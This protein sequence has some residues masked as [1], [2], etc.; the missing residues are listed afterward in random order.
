MLRA[1]GSTRPWG[2]RGGMPKCQAKSVWYEMAM[3]LESSHAS[4]DCLIGVVADLE[5]AFNAIPRQPVW[6][7]LHPRECTST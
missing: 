3:L 6:A 4:K 2:M 1:L 5:K 7:A